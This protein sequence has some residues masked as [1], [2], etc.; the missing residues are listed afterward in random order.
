MKTQSTDL[1]SYRF[2]GAPV[3]SPDGSACAYLMWRCNEDK[4]GY[5]SF[6]H[7]LALPS[8]E[9][10]PVA[11]PQGCTSLAW[12]ADGRLCAALPA[13]K[14]TVLYAVSPSGACDIWATLPF[15]AQILDSLANGQLLMMASRPIVPEKAEEDG[16]FTVLDEFPF[17]YDGRGFISKV[18][19]Q[20]F[21]IRSHGEPELISP[22]AMDV[23]H[24][25]C[26]QDKSR[27]VFSGKMVETVRPDWDA[28]ADYT[29]AS[30]SLRMVVSQRQWR[31]RQV[32]LFAGKPVI[33]ASGADESY[34]A[35]P[36]IIQFDENGTS[37]VLADPGMHI[38]NSVVSDV[39]YGSGTVLLGRSDALY[40]V[41]TQGYG[42]QLYKMDRE[43]RIVQLTSE[44]GSVDGFDVCGG[45][46][47]FSGLRNMRLPEIYALAENGEHRLSRLNGG[48]CSP[49]PEDLSVLNSEGAQVFGLVRVPDVPPDEKCP[50]VLVIHGGPNGAFGHVFHHEM[51]LLCDM[52]Y[53]VACCNPTGSDGRGA[54]FGDISGRWGT[55]DYDDIMRFTDAFLA[56]HP[57]IDRSRVAVFGGSYGGYMVNWIIGH[58]NR[59][60]CA[61]SDRS[62]S[63]CPSK[64]VTGDNGMS[65]GK[66]HMKTDVYENP[67]YMWDRS[68]LKYAHQVKTPTLF[69][70]GEADTRCHLS[71]ATMMFTA[72]R[73]HGVTARMAIFKGETHELCR[74]GKPRNRIRRLNEAAQ[75]LEAYCK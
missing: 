55:V 30:G 13:D 5:T 45:Q 68:P 16:R 14:E 34:Y 22:A 56:K 62:I 29:V 53:Y 36:K 31:I 58:T 21:V 26:G 69:I 42:S 74:T 38:A 46:I 27:V 25:S 8:G 15:G 51:Q 19:K 44:E 37:A 28:L 67:E 17:W 49:M 70:H 33:I 75:W 10:L 23:E 39:R 73:E 66:M 47:V 54:A 43:N 32:A 57:Q 48:L 20:L 61:I 59:F 65:F 41:A 72:I 12:L 7:V 11:A 60:C 64:D 71:Q 9:A 6:V 52:G 40:F 3:I 50:A 63:N 24:A 35:A 18:R 2:A 4:S 1:L